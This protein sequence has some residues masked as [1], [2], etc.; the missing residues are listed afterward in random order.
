MWQ[1]E[2]TLGKKT[3]G[4]AARLAPGWQFLA[5]TLGAI[6]WHAAAAQYLPPP[7]PSRPPS[8]APSGSPT[9]KPHRPS[10]PPKTI[11]VTRETQ[12]LY[13]IASGPL[14]FKTLNC[15]EQTY[16]DR[17]DLQL[18]RGFKGGTVVFRSGRTCTIDK[19]FRDVDPYSLDGFWP[20]QS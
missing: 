13:R 11:I 4:R 1:R 15:Y 6:M 18:I 2:C 19:F 5:A 3:Q 14:Y 9:A 10:G 7:T 20:G 16:A 12:D 8:D 17:A